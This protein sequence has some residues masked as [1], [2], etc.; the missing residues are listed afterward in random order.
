MSS[1][2]TKPPVWFWIVAG[3]GVVWNIVGI[4][5]FIGMTTINADALS[6]MPAAERALYENTPLITTIAFAVAV[7]G[8]LIGAV[9]LLLRKSLA[10]TF[11][12]ASLL[13]IIVQFGYWLFMSGASKVY[14]PGELY[15]MPAMVTIIAVFLLW[16]ARMSRARGWIA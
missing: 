12:I 5:S 16:F 8:G 15:A 10:T 3:V 1:I 14:S 6:Q 9:L 11:F 4:L 2:I 13:G 7:F